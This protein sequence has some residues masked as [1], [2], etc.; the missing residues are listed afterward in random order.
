EN[1]KYNWKVAIRKFEIAADDSA[2]PKG[3]A[4]LMQII[5]TVNWQESELVDPREVEL[6]TLRL[7]NV[8]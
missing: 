5:V 2:Q 4:E 1:E 8:K 7:I 3:K 6:N